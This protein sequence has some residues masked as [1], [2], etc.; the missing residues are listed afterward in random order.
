MPYYLTQA[1]YTPEAMSAQ[2]KSLQDIRD[3]LGPMLET[4]GIRLV[5]VFYAFGEYDLVAITEAPD[6]V[7]AAASG[8]AVA[9]GGALKAVKTTPLMTIEEGLEAMKRA[10]GAGYRPPGT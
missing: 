9:A 2:I 3:R 8:F 7:A 6:N 10:S 4:L 1:T 5:E